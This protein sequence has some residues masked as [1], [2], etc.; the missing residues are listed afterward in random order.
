MKLA[1]AI[2]IQ[3]SAFILFWLLST[4]YGT[5]FALGMRFPK[6]SYIN[7]NLP[8]LSK[9]STITPEAI[10]NWTS[11][12]LNRLQSFI[13]Q[14]HL[15]IVDAGLRLGPVTTTC[16]LAAL[17]IFI[18][19]SLDRM[20]NDNSESADSQAQR[21]LQQSEQRLAALEKRVQES[22]R[23]VDE[24]ERRLREAEARVAEARRGMVEAAVQAAA[25]RLAAP[26]MERRM[27][28]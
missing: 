11:W 16:V 1:Q 28:R 13:W 5:A 2:I 26:E 6:P 20:L 12:L 23:R 10:R 3:L 14:C 17:Q 27:A 22:R 21:E 7:Y 18:L 15:S 19:L 9:F 8:E 4:L 25:A 24:A